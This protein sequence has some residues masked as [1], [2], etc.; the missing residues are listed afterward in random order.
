MRNKYNNI[1]KNWRKNIDRA[2]TGS[3]LDV[4][5]EPVWF[6]IMHP[7]LTDTN[8]VID[9]LSSSA[10]DLSFQEG[11][12]SAESSDEKNDEETSDKEN[13]NVLN[14]SELQEQSLSPAVCERKENQTKVLTLEVKKNNYKTT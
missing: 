9:S 3:W 4:K 13:E 12:L 1:K 14:Q 8:T 10:L 11:N 5:K 6:Q 2:R 7:V